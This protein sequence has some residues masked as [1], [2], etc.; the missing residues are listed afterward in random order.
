MPSIA[1]D[2]LDSQPPGHGL[3]GLFAGRPPGYAGIGVAVS[4]DGGDTWQHTSI[5]LPDGFDQA[6]PTRSSDSTIRGACSSASWRRHS[7]GR[8]RR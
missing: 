2:P 4:H 7:W 8:S 6:P 5:P 1:V 3:H